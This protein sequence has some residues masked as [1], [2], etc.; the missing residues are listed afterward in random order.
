MLIKRQKDPMDLWEIKDKEE[1]LRERLSD[2]YLALT[3]YNNKTPPEERDRIR[4]LIEELAKSEK[5]RDVVVFRTL[6]IDRDRKLRKI[7]RGLLADKKLPRMVVYLP[8][9]SSGSETD[10]LS[11]G[12]V[13]ITIDIVLRDSRSSDGLQDDP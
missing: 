13:K 2:Q 11:L 4:E 1:Y 9:G 6:N 12:R 7:F 5:Y 3:Y 8:G 10:D